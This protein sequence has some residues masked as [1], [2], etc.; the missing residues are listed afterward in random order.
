[1]QNG[2]ASQAWLTVPVAISSHDI[3]CNMFVAR[4]YFAGLFEI[5]MITAVCVHALKILG[6]K[7]D[8]HS[9]QIVWFSGFLNMELICL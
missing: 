3:F 7:G 8:S 4:N 5:N 2:G 9:L 6:G 1:M